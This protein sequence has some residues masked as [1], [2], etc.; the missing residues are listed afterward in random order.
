MAQDR[1]LKAT[2]TRVDPRDHDA[3]VVD[4]DGHQFDEE[5]TC[6]CGWTWVEHQSSPV[7]CTRPRFNYEEEII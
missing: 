4:A 7:T 6:R 3:E 1:G 2:G 5:M